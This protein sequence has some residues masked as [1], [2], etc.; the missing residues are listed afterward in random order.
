MEGSTERSL[1]SP[2]RSHC[3]SQKEAGGEK[4]MRDK[5][6]KKRKRRALLV[7]YSWAPSPFSSLD[8]NLPAC[9]RSETLKSALSSCKP[10]IFAGTSTN[11][12][13]HHQRAANGLQP[14]II[15]ADE[16]SICVSPNE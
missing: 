13:A 6:R 15:S 4:Q 12:D 9:F 8:L 11:E 1:P 3:P 7:K 10:L 5:G 16:C 2:S 14:T